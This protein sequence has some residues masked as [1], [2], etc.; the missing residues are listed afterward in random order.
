M[1]H[2]FMYAASVS[3]LNL[4]IIGL[5]WLVSPISPLNR[6]VTVSA[7]PAAVEA[8]FRKEN[9][10]SG[11]PAR[12]V[13]PA[14]GIDLPVDD[15]VYDA[16]SGTWNIANKKAFYAT[17]TPLVNNDRGNTLIYGHNNH[18]VFKA[19]HDAKPGMELL[20]YTDNG[21]VFH[22]I[23]KD[24]QEVKPTNTK[25]LRYSNKSSVTLQT[26]SGNWNEWRK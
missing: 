13:L 20:V 4:C 21:K 3:L 10:I 25:V 19:L 11:K 16:A 24:A 17:I 2:K 18:S 26:C 6:T 9:T 12:V 8:Q 5:V 23:Y 14:L 1:M 7:A 22:Y 15:G